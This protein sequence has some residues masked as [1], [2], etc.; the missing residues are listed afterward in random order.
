LLEI[1]F[2]HQTWSWAITHLAG[3]FRTPSV[4]VDPS[5]E[6][7]ALQNAVAPEYARPSWVR[8]RCKHAADAVRTWARALDRAMPLHDQVTVCVFA[9]G[10][11]THVLLVAGLHNPTVRRRY[12]AVCE[13]LA[14]YGRL[15]FH[16]RLLALLGCAQMDRQRVEHH[17]AAVTTAFDAATVAIKTPYRF[18][19]DISDVA[20]RIS[21]DGSRELIELGLHREAIFWIAATYS[22]CRAIFAVDAPDLLVRFDDGYGALLAD[23]GIG[24]FPDRQTRCEKVEAFLPE[25]WPVVEEILSANHGIHD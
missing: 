13:A 15:D 17:L 21:I 5:G 14:E 19:S 10:V 7:T 23:L 4:I 8:R 2:G 25:L 11:T 20:R 16:E 18:G 3:A 6:L 12:A 9:A 22:R 1:G 24:S